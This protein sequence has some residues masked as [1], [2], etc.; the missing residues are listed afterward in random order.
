[1][2]EEVTSSADDRLYLEVEKDLEKAIIERDTLAEENER[3]EA[4]LDVARQSIAELARR[5]QEAEARE[6][7][8]GREVDALI[9]R[10]QS[11][12]S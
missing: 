10:F 5:A 11:S 2:I 7:R 6:I 8:K 3:L 9:D 12:R 4:E 1:V